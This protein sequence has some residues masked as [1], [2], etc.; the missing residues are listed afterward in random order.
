MIIWIFLKKK[1]PSVLPPTP[2]P[3]PGQDTCGSI[4]PSRNNAGKDEH[5]GVFPWWPL[6]GDMCR[7][8][9]RIYT[10]VK[11]REI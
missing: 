1:N 7:F 10:L 5:V 4:C 8:Q 3:P 2:E 6:A 9:G 11:E